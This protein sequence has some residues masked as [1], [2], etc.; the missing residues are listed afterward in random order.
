MNKP[1]TVTS[2]AFEARYARNPDPWSFANSPYELDRYDRLVEILQRHRYETIYEPGCSVG[3]LTERLA[4]I[5]RRVIAT[6]FA[7]TAV[8]QAK[9]R[10]ANLDNVDIL[11]ADLATFMPPQPLDLIVFSEVGYYFSPSELSGITS[12]LAKCLSANGEF[13]AVHWLGTSDDHVLHGDQVHAVLDTCL[14]LNPLKSAFHPGFRLNYW[15]KA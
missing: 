8:E 11:C 15:A 3:V 9:T 7:A 5:S 14:N 2:A 6:D 4:R 10:C 13:I 12:R 1:W